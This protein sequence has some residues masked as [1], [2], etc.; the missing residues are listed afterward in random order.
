M[1]SNASFFEQMLMKSSRNFYSRHFENFSNCQTNRQLPY[2]GLCFDDIFVLSDNAY[3]SSACRR[4]RKT[5]PDSPVG[6]S[7]KSPLRRTISAADVP[8]VYGAIFIIG[9]RGGVGRYRGRGQVFFD[10]F[11]R[12][13]FLKLF[14]E[15]VQMTFNVCRFCKKYIRF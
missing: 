3:C 2:T 14:Q 6:G 8:N 5:A 13:F 4:N 1:P 11:L 10:L 9:R 15:I 7:A 12:E